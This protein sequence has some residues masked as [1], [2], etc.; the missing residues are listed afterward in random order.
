MRSAVYRKHVPAIAVMRT[1]R[2]TWPA[3]I[4]LA[5]LAFGAGVLAAPGRDRS[6]GVASGILTLIVFSG[7][8]EVARL[9]GVVSR[10]ALEE[11][12]HHSSASGQRNPGSRSSPSSAPS[13]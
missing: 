8:R 5:A 12:L 11:S 3:P 6:S 1:A 9:V 10:S 13:G 7:G 2:P 4:V